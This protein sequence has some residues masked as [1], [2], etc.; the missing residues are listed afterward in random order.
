MDKI[1]FALIIVLLIVC[2]I[3]LYILLKK[4]RKQEEIEEVRIPKELIKIEDIQLPKKIEKMPQ[5]ILF[6]SCT[7]IF[8]IFK[9]LDYA[10]KSQ[11][12]LN[13]YEWH[14]WQISLLLSLIKNDKS[15]FI[16]NPNTLFH[17]VILDKPKQVIQEEMQ[18]IL[19][20]YNNEVNILKSRDDLS[21]DINWSPKE[22]SII[23]YYM[24]KSNEF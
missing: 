12:I 3:L 20:K 5:H 24:S 11:K 18:H 10:S 8:D 13:N 6:H 17:K 16:P 15:F 2:I 9:T 23:F 14:S 7:K 21:K 4:Y 19:N 1:L 22:V